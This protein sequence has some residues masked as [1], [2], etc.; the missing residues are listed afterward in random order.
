MDR[1]KGFHLDVEDY[2]AGVLILA[3]ELVR[4][5]CVFFNNTK[6]C[7]CVKNEKCVNVGRLALVFL[8]LPVMIILR[9]FYK[10]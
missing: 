10:I 5:E 1:E 8:W 4:S 9:Y 6:N 3:S 2:L 7:A